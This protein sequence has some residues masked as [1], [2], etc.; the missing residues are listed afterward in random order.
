M[1]RERLKGTFDSHHS[2]DDDL[3][4][5]SIA[6]RPVGDDDGVVELAEGVGAGGGQSTV[7][8]AGIA[9]VEVVEAEVR[10]IGHS[11]GSSGCRCSSRQPA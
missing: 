2:L 6:Q 7:G 10:A 8:D 3:E 5:L 9:T 11:G 4:R 1:T